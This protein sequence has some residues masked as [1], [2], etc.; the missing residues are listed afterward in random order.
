M[1][2]DKYIYEYFNLQS[3]NKALELIKDSKVLVNN[4]IITKA[5]FIVE[6]SHKVIVDTQ[7]FYVS[8]SA[9]KL[10]L[11]LDELKHISNLNLENY[12]ALDIGSSTGGFTQILLENNINSVTC[13][14]VGKEQLHESIKEYKNIKIFEN[15]DIRDFKSDEHFHIVTCDVS[16]ISIHE[17]LDSINKLA[18]HKI[19]ILFKPQF[20]VGKDAKRDSK[21]VL[22]DT[23]Q[24]EFAK[25]KFKMA[26]QKLS[27]KLI[28]QNK[29]Q[30]M[31]KN[32]NQEE[33]Y[34]FEK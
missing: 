27:W 12:N 17:I 32:G 33:L 14:D 9:K 29:S 22:K 34:Y 11:F 7:D 26:T 2:L 8:R 6:T 28:Y 23:R 18:K 20:E 15:T 10:K 31:G 13:V 24:I 5:S 25:D 3:R 1:R 19:I 16:F 30:I 4:K 21:G